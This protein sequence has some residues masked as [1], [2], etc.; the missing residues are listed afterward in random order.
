[1][2]IT[3]FICEKN[4]KLLFDENVYVDPKTKYYLLLQFVII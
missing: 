3:I 2:Q 1:M 4:L